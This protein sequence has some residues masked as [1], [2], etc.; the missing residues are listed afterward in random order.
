MIEKLENSTIVVL[1]SYV[2]TGNEKKEEEWSFAYIIPITDRLITSSINHL[3]YYYSTGSY[4][5]Y[6]SQLKNQFLLTS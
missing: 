1:L 4:L 2:T 6:V 3:T 5:K